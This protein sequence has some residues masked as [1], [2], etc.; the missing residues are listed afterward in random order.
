ML[1][2]L[3]SLGTMIPG[4][5]EKIELIFQYCLHRRPGGIFQVK[6]ILQ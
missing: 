4:S 2:I 6:E 1:L 5:P 3:P